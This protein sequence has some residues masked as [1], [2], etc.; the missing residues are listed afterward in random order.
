[1]KL[2][3]MKTMKTMKPM[4]PMKIMSLIDAPESFAVKRDENDLF[5]RGP[6]RD[7]NMGDDDFTILEHLRKESKK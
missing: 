7:I 2:K 6:S 4:K 1:M 3:T 5:F